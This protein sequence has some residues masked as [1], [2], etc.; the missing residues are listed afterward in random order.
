[1]LGPFVSEFPGC[2]NVMLARTDYIVT[3]VPGR[4][5]IAKWTQQRP[6]LKAEP[7]EEPS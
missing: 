6:S 5:T 3:I 4:L 1:M 2:W 7:S